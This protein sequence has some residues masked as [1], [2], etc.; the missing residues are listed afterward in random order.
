VDPQKK[1]AK[2][3]IF[4]SEYSIQAAEDPVYIEQVARYVDGKMREL[5]GNG[6]V[7]SAT[8]VAILAAMNIADELHKALRSQASWQRMVDDR[9]GEL[10]RSL[11]GKANE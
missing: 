8:K 4:G 3:S 11:E 7:L 6:A 9:A 1:S 5:Q 2:V 10:A